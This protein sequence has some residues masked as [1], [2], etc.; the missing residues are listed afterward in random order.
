MGF[1]LF[2]TGTGRFFCL[3]CPMQ[4]QWGY[5]PE[6]QPSTEDTTSNQHLD[7]ELLVL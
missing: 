5:K 3:L 2:K 1:V 6:S 4:L 7:L